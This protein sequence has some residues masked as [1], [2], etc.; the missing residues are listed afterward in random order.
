MDWCGRI[1]ILTGTLGK[2]LGGAS[3]GYVSARAEIVELLRQRSRPYLF[4]NSVAPGIVAGSLA[5]LDLLEAD[6][7][8]VTRLRE[9]TAYF[10]EAMARTG[11][12]ILPGAHP[13]VP[14]ML[15]DARSAARLAERLLEEGVYVIAFS[16]PVVPQGQARILYPSFRRPHPGRPRGRRPIVLPDATMN[17]LLNLL[18][19]IAL[20]AVAHAEVESPKTLHD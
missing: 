5:A 17:A 3:G 15:G 8:L 4:S 20:A 13:V 10:R 1:D 2:A 18:S 19:V 6:S 16:F 9:N 14:V 12:T 11:L 7:S